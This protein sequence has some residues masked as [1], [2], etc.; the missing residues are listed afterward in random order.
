M[1]VSGNG[2]VMMTRCT[3]RDNSAASFGGGIY[4]AGGSQLIISDSLINN[5]TAF[6]GGGGMYITSY[7]TA[8]MMTACVLTSNVVDKNHEFSTLG[9]GGAITVYGS[10][11]LNMHD[12]QVIGNAAGYYGSGMYIDSDAMSGRKTVV[13][14]MNCT[15]AGNY[16]LN[17]NYGGGIYISTAI[18]SIHY[19]I[20]I[21][22]TAGFAGAGVFVYLESELNMTNCIVS[23]NTVK[24]DFPGGGMYIVGLKRFSI[25]NTTV[26]NNNA[27][28]G[29]GMYISCGDGEMINC[30]V[31]GNTANGYSVGGGG[32]CV[33][34]VF[35]EMADCIITNNDANAHGGGL[36]VMRDNEDT[37]I[38]LIRCKIQ[39]NT[40]QTGNTASGGGMHV[41]GGASVTMDYC[42]VSENTADY[43]GG[44]VFV[45]DSRSMVQMINTVVY[46]NAAST[47]IGFIINGNGGGLCVMNEASIQGQNVTLGSNAATNGGA[48]V[49]MFGSGTLV[50]LRDSL[51]T[52]NKVFGMTKVKNGGGVSV[53]SSANVWLIGCSITF[54]TA[55]NGSGLY[56]TGGGSAATLTDCIVDDNTASTGDHGGYGGGVYACAV[57]Q[58]NIDSCSFSRNT[59][60]GGGGVLYATDSYTVI[61]MSSTTATR[62]TRGVSLESCSALYLSDDTTIC[63]N[64]EY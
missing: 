56:V 20:V 40:A 23:Y 25:T 57:A 36:F 31:T 26:S 44:G 7:R 49:Y 5:N 14:M 9:Y 10:A 46:G 61:N 42:D 27:Y 51:I 13:N 52:N 34:D 1:H 30:K 50:V 17:D 55:C 62:N 41:R 53:I 33:V 16:E 15:V 3:V 6:D 4:I 39:G 32:V 2:T 22:N 59:G 43:Y 24:G 21:N 18:V 58:V 37:A 35:V 64:D 54:N 48:G 8:V 29:G 45:T 11:V 28:Y 47:T 38:T 60:G 12:T 63:S 19:T